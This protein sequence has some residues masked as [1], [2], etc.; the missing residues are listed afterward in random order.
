MKTTLLASLLAGLAGASFAA[1]PTANLNND[2]QTYQN[3][4]HKAATD[5]KT[6][7][8]KCDTLAAN[9]RNVC[10]HEANAARAHAEADAV[11]QYKHSA[12]SA[13]RA[14][15]AAVD[16]DFA[17]AKAKCAGMTGAD[18][19]NCLATARSNHA[20]ALADAKAGRHA[21]GTAVAAAGAVP[22]GMSTD[23]AAA[24]E[25]C[26]NATGSDN[27]ACLL[28]NGK[29]PDA[30]AAR[31][32]MANAAD[33]TAAAAANATDRAAANT[34]AAADNAADA[35]AVAAQN[36]HAAAHDMAQDTRAAAHEVAQDTRQAAHSVAEKTREVA[37]DVAAKTR[38]ATANTAVE[39]RE[40]ARDVAATTDHAATRT[41]NAVADSVITTKVKADFVKEPDLSALAIHVETEKGVVMLSGFVN[42]KTEAERAV[43]VARGVEGVTKVKSALKVK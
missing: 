29:H 32:K 20:T 22:N 36:T 6:A 1:A 7:V 30:T 25:R 18:K 17:L 11:A 40:A 15:V 33:R 12:T 39:S 8:A 38:Q 24:I 10:M 4:T 31:Q 26:K 28:D 3:L 34:H 43:Q 23:K 19:D 41:G 2:V 35:T 27:T 42:S 13:T 21:T 5:Y 16:A 14:D 9:A 37:H